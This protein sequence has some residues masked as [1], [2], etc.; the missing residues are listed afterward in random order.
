MTTYPGLPGPAVSDFLS[1][2]QSR[3]RYCGGTTFHIG[4]IQMVG[5]TG[6]YVDA[7][8]HRFERGADLA[9]LTLARLADVPGRVFDATGAGR[10]IGPGLFAGDDLAGSAVLIRTGWDR[11]WRT[12]QYGEG[13]PFLTRAAA[14]RLATS[15][16]ALVGID[17]VNIDDMTDG[18]R[19]A[20]TL[21]L[22]GGIPI[23]E[24]LCNLAALPESGFRLHAV[25]AP[26]GGM[27]S[28]PVRAYAVIEEEER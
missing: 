12:P 6:T 9:A 26:F 14:G 7:P 10:A 22:E 23:V 2:E 21:L 11:H 4:S 24:H 18:T 27:G 25:P 3:P 28:F 1:R 5:N 8:F 19:P 20:H 15:G 16:A 17:S 13:H